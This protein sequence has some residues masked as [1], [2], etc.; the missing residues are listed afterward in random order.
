MAV[1]E[2]TQQLWIL[3]IRRQP[4]CVCQAQTCVLV[5][6]SSELADRSM[7]TPY[8]PL[9]FSVLRN[10]AHRQVLKQLAISMLGFRGV[11]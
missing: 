8:R 1:Q 5:P 10:I 2:V 6:H 11:V 7:K 3:S 4:V 9:A